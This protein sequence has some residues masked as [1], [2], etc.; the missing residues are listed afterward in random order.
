MPPWLSTLLVVSAHPFRL[1]FEI[2]AWPLIRGNT[3]FRN[4][5]TRGGGCLYGDRRLCP[6][7]NPKPFYIPFFTKKVLLS[8][9]FY[10]Q[11]VPLSRTFFRTLHLLAL[12]EPFTDPHD[13]SPPFYI[14]QKVTEIP[15]LS[16]TWGLKKIPLSG[17]TF[18][19][20]PSWGVPPHP[21][22]SDI[23]GRLLKNRAGIPLDKSTWKW[24]R[25]LEHYQTKTERHRI[26]K[27]VKWR[28]QWCKK[29]RQPKE[30]TK[31]LPKI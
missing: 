25:N 8:Y 10:W 19:Y 15:T 16:Y 29:R 13:K 22:G 30:Q 26:T 28:K 5:D 17:R 1:K 12:L 2:S 9:T 3:V 20:R 31:N 4:S 11:M 27:M 7:V 14:L 23:T 18:P 24:H 21:L 6:E